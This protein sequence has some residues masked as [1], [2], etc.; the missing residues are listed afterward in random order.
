MRFGS[1]WPQGG[2]FTQ[3]SLRAK[4]RI[5]NCYLRDEFRVESVGQVIEVG[6]MPAAPTPTG[7]VAGVPAA[8]VVAEVP[9]VSRVASHNLLV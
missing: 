9:R 4:I 3:P 8:A 1:L 5:Q 7:I 2:K 6:G